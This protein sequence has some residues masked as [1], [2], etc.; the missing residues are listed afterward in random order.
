[1]GVE[2]YRSTEGEGKK[3]VP[4]YHH[5]RP[6]EYSLYSVVRQ[7]Q[8]VD[9]FDFEGAYRWLEKEVGFYPLFLAVGPTEE[10]KRMTGYQNQWRRLLARGKDLREYRKKGEIDNQ[11]LLS[12]LNISDGIFMDYEYWHIVLNS[13]LNDYEVNKWVKKLIFRPT[14][15]KN[16]WLD[17]AEREP[18][19][20]QLIVPELDLREAEVVWVRNRKTQEELKNI[21]FPNVEVRRLAVDRW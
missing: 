13:A 9:F 5:A 7:E 16:R 19:S 10:D 6:L 21:G 8:G 12:F 20:V 17:Y 18:H 1:M 15:N 2:N 14:W 11:V 3:G 4:L